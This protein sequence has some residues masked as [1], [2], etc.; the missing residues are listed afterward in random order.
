[1]GRKR[2]P[3]IHEI[4]AH[5]GTYEGFVNIPKGGLTGI[6][7]IPNE[8]ER[9]FLVSSIT[10]NCIYIVREESQVLF[11]HFTSPSDVAYDSQRNVVIVPNINQNS[12]QFREFSPED[13][14]IFNQ[15]DSN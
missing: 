15:D 5:L 6:A 10:C 14:Y 2:L 1:M 13:R 7:V 8:K 11:K 9:T 12:I 4:D 3:K